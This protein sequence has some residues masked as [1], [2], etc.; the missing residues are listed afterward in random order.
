[1]IYVCVHLQVSMMGITRK[2]NRYIVMFIYA[3]IVMCLCQYDAGGCMEK[4]TAMKY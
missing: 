3:L 4:E 2:G 1:M